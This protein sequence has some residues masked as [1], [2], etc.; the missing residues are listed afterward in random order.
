MQQRLDL[1]RLKTAHPELS[2]SQIAEV[3]GVTKSVAGNT[4]RAREKWSLRAEKPT[5]QQLAEKMFGSTKGASNGV[6]LAVPD[7]HAPYE[8][9]DALEF[10]KSVRDKYRPSEFVCL[11]DEV[12]FHSVSRWPTNPDGMSAGQELS[13]AIE[14]LQP[15]YK[16]FPLMAVCTSNHTARPFRKAFDAGLP[17]AFL[18]A[19][20]T[21]LK[22]PEGWQWKD[23]WEFDGVRYIH[24]EGKSGQGA[25][26]SFMRG[27]RQSIVHGHVHSFAAVSHEG[28]LFAVNSGCLIDAQSYA[29]AYA[30]HMP[31]SVSLGCS[32]IHSGK[33]AEFIPMVTDKH[34]R[35]VGKL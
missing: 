13:K 25:H 18:P 10:L 14:H 2:F 12:D 28:E 21:L 29:F 27:Y 7:L 30:K 24:G 34:G 6:V 32:V 26:I 16:E 35:W 15:F 9:I 20:Q 5:P 3:I 23:Y 19:Y 8:H 33:R 31:I 11:G 22:A 4:W 1:I 17:Q